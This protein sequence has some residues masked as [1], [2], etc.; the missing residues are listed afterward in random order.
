MHVSGTLADVSGE[1]RRAHPWRERLLHSTRRPNFTAFF[2]R[3]GYGKGISQTLAVFK[4]EKLPFVSIAH[5]RPFPLGSQPL[6]ATKIDGAIC[7]RY[8]KCGALRATC[9]HERVAGWQLM[10]R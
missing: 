8:Q 2:A 6:F 9:M 5:D 1:G 3:G 10:R 7:A 4:L